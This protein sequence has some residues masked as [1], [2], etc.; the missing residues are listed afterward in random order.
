VIRAVGLALLPS[1]CLI[2]STHDPSAAAD[3]GA[4]A[5]CHPTRLDYVVLASLADSPNWMSL[6]AYPGGPVKSGRSGRGN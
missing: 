4:M 5:G 1:L 3:L 6:S 2:A